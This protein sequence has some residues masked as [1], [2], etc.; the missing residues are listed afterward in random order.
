MLLN[1]KAPL[2][3]QVKTFP[4]LAQTFHA[5]AAEGKDGFYKGR[6]A[7]AIVDLIQSKGGV[8]ELEDLAAHKTDLVE[9]IKYTYGGEVTVYEVHSVARNLRSVILLK[10]CLLQCPPNGQG[11][12]ALMTLGILDSI[13]EQG[14][15]KPLLEMEHNSPEYLHTLVEALRFVF[16]ACD[17]QT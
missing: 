13:Q 6:V 4:T 10:T 1:G 15:I 17:V 3:G 16:Q 7:Q 8:M 14:K 5:V 9:P 2:P 12:T 11:L